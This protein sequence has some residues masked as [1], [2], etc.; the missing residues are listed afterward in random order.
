MLLT[1]VAYNLKKQLKY[2]PERQV[3]LAVAL[4]R[5]LLADNRRARR[6]NSPP[7]SAHLGAGEVAAHK[8]IA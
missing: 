1:A 3:S 7:Q 8:K 5:P 2:R 4:P 6:R